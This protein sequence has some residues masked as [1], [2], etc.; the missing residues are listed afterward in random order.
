MTNTA[1]T[2]TTT[3]NQ[4]QAPTMAAYG[5]L[6]I[7]VGLVFE[8]EFPVFRGSFRNATYDGVAK[9]KGKITSDSYG[10]KTG[11][12]TF[13]FLVTESDR[14]DEFTVGQTYRKVGKNMYPSI[15]SYEYPVNYEAVAEEKARRAKKQAARNR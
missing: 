2:T 5:R 13:T 7:V 10:K 4:T 3:A 9:V 11:K 1:T 12:H 6:N 8:A 15:L 14:P